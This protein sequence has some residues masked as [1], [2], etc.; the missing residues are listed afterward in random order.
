MRKIGL[1]LAVFSVFALAA[2]GPGNS[3]RL[4]PAPPLEAASLPAPNAPS[5]CIVNF[6]D[7]RMDPAAVGVRRDGSS[8][9]TTG[10][11][12]LWISRSLADELARKGFRVTFAMAASQAKSANP[13]YIVTG[14][15]QEVWL[16]EA[17][18]TEMSVQMRM[19]CTLANRKGKLW[20]ESCSTSQTKTSLPSG[21]FA[22]N[23]LLDTMRDLIGPVAQKIYSTIETK[24]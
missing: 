3:V 17:S 23:L 15:V 7:N 19:D 1:F 6:G 16:K 5:V 12:A 18:A 2:C 4:L 10:D 8:F 20:T 22:D 9:T 14:V 11:V 21:S 13:D 24:K